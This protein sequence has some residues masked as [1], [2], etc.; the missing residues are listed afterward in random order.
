MRCAC[1]R[2]LGDGHAEHQARLVGV[3]AHPRLE[4][5]PQG[6]CDQVN[7]RVLVASQRWE[8]GIALPAHSQHCTA[9]FP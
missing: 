2:C 7:V 8:S 6:V 9:A 1:K 3:Y 4:V 5:P